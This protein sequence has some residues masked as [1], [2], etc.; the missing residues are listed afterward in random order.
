MLK[1]QHKTLARILD[2]IA[3][4]SPG[5]YGLFWDRDGVMPWKEFYWALQEDPS[6]RFVRESS[7]RELALLGIELPFLLEGNLL[8]LAAGVSPP[9]YPLATELPERLFYGIRP[10]MLV[11]AQD[12]GLRS[13]ARPFI[14]LSADRELAIRIAKRREKEPILVEVLASKALASG[15]PFMT[16][17][18]SLYLA[19][20]VP[21]EFILFPRI[22]QDLAARLLSERAVKPKEKASPPPAPGSFTVSPGHVTA[23]GFG[24]SSAKSGKSSKGGWKKDSR[25]ERRK[26]D[27]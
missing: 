16:A 9:D 17:G 4:R 26:R 6:L 2:Y 13:S 21:V 1:H 12:F 18:P 8:R 22:R 11:K 7:I 23:P 24:K 15:V 14:P 5:E 20:S 3:R 10:K 27:I 19:E 25:K